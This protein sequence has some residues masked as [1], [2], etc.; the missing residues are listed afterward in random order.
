MKTKWGLGIA[1]EVSFL[2]VFARPLF[3]LL[4]PTESLL[5]AN[6]TSTTALV[7]ITLVSHI[8]QNGS[9]NFTWNGI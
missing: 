6:E 7:M 5:Q 8:L 3:L 4:A 9:N 2:S 1:G